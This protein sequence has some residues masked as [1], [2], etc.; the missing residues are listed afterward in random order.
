MTPVVIHHLGHRQ[1]FSNRGGATAG[2]GASSLGQKADVTLEFKN[3]GEDLFTIIYGKCRIGGLYH[4]DGPSRWRTPTTA[5]SRCRVRVPEPR[6]NSWRR[7]WCR[8]SLRHRKDLTTSSCAPSW[9][10]AETRGGRPRD[11]LDDDDRVRGVEKVQQKTASSATRRSGGPRGALGVREDSRAS[12][13]A[14]V[15]P[16]DVRH[17]PRTIQVGRRNHGGPVPPPNRAAKKRGALGAHLTRKP[18]ERAL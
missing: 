7:R 14:T 5:A 15:D 3:A 9:A 2:R 6:S 1:M 10:V 13:H 11:G 8:P 17:A 4:P 16:S 18:R 12:P